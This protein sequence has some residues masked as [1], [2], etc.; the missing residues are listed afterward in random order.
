MKRWL[1][2]T[3]SS[4]TSL[5]NF[6]FLSCCPAQCQ[7][8]ANF[9]KLTAHIPH[10]LCIARWP[11]SLQVQSVVLLNCGASVDLQKHLQQ[12][13]GENSSSKRKTDTCRTLRGRC[14]VVMGGFSTFSVSVHGKFTHCDACLARICVFG[15][16][17]M[18]VWINGPESTA[19]VQAESSWLDARPQSDLLCFPSEL[20][21]PFSI[22][23]RCRPMLCGDQVGDHVKCFVID[24]HRP[25]MPIGLQ[26]SAVSNPSGIGA[27]A[28]FLRLQVGA[29]PKKFVR[30]IT[31]NLFLAKRLSKPS[32]LRLENMSKH[33]QRVVVLDDDPIAENRGDSML[34]S[35]QPSR[36]KV[37]PSL[38]FGFRN[39]SICVYNYVPPCLGQALDTHTHNS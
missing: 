29:H 4:W 1:A 14:V 8:C 2:F 32:W 9:T 35:L 20:P 18:D 3:G 17:S 27:G 10:R 34:S 30:D 36:G 16:V 28:G 11:H 26:A 37:A 6:P 15:K 12:A 19:P 5:E 13:G 39:R 33:N 25:V 22:S 24:A 21:S 31:L 38:P 23:S 7:H